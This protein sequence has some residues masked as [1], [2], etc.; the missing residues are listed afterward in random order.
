MGHVRQPILLIRAACGSWWVPSI[1]HIIKGSFVGK[2]PSICHMK[3]ARTNV[4][5][6]V[7]IGIAWDRIFAQIYVRRFARRYVRRYVRVNIRTH[8][9][10]NVWIDVRTCNNFTYTIR[11]RIS[12]LILL[13]TIYYI[14]RCQHF[15]RNIYIS[16]GVTR[17]RV[18]SM[19]IYSPL[20]S[21]SRW[22]LY[23]SR[24]FTYLNISIFMHFQFSTAIYFRLQDGIYI[25]V[26]VCFQMEG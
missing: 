20:I 1:L 2:L 4:G 22:T 3:F 16:V 11:I 25:Q 10:K 6:N 21:H 15:C 23:S 12:G 13:Y 17:R 9:G 14:Y 8:V 5:I 18:K 7:N 26:P 19:F 24:W